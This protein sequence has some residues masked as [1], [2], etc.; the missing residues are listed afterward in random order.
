MTVKAI[1][2]GYHTLTPYL[3][4]DNAAEAL[5]FY[6]EA[7]NAREIYRFDGPDGKIG[8]A[9][10]QIGDSRLM[11]ADEYPEKGHTGPKVL[12]GSPV[13]LCLYV[14]DVDSLFQQAIAAGA[15][16]VRAVADQFYGDRTGM[17]RDPFGHVWS[18]ST[19]KED[20]SA[21]EMTRR[22]EH[23]KEMT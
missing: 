15:Q 6:G 14:E 1:P 18:I 11:L 9:E 8:H 10:M 5:R 16:E 3:A 12:G 2:E 4:V 23:G 7:F 19:H 21:E 17:L 20:V 13:M 22:V